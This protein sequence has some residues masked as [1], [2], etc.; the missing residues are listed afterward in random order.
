MKLAAVVWL[1]VWSLTS[2]SI[3][4]YACW[5]RSNHVAASAVCGSAMRC[6]GPHALSS[7]LLSMA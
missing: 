5:L 3:H 2:L 1:P 4:I 6:C 7:M